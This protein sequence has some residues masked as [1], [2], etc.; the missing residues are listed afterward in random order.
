SAGLRTLGGQ[1]YISPALTGEVEAG[2]GAESRELIRRQDLAAVPC[3]YLAAREAP[4]GAGSI[5]APKY[6]AVGS[7][8]WVEIETITIPA[9]DTNTFSNSTDRNPANRRMPY[10][11]DWRRPVIP[12]DAELTFDVDQIGSVVAGSGIVGYIQT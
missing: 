9:G 11:L 12:Q 1:S 3:S 5:A 10:T 8:S 7:G 4:R 2:V 6:R